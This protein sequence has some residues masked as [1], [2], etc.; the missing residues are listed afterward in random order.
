MS[1]RLTIALSSASLL[2][3]G[4]AM[5]QT[6]GNSSGPAA[7]KSVEPSTAIQKQEGR[8]ADDQSTVPTGAG[9]PGVEAKPGTQSG[10]FPK[11]NMDSNE[12][13]R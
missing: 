6:A 2:L 3:A 9:A 12:K 7:G 10:A 13:P 5:A 1:K 11:S 4:V 8:S